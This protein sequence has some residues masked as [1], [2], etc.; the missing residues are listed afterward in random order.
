MWHRPLWSIGASWRSAVGC[1][2]RNDAIIDCFAA[3]DALVTHNGP[4]N[5]IKL[6]L[7]VGGGSNQI[8]W[9]HASQPPE[10]HLDQFSRSCGAHER[11]RQTD[12]PCYSVCSNRLHLAT[13]AIQSNISMHHYGCV[14][15]YEASILQKGRFWAASLAS[16]SSTSNEVRSPFMFLSKMELQCSLKVIH[17]Y[18]TRHFWR[19]EIGWISPDGSFGGKFEQFYRPDDIAVI[20]TTMSRRCTCEKFTQVEWYR[21]LQCGWR[22][23]ESGAPAFRSLQLQCMRW[24]CD[25]LTVPTAARRNLCHSTARTMYIV[26]RYTYIS[27]FV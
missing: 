3:H 4:D 25:M 21:S 23:P 17:F 7:R 27:F 18:L 8:P 19:K 6:P 20:Q 14:V 12:R 13:A 5:P 11:D 26:H 24:D 22:S 2:S 16:G 1:H 9:V 15:L 10:W